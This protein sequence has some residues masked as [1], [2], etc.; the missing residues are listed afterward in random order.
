MLLETLSG[1]FRANKFQR[2]FAA[3]EVLKKLKKPVWNVVY[4]HRKGMKSSE[5]RV[6]LELNMLAYNTTTSITTDITI[7]RFK[8]MYAKYSTSFCVCLK[9]VSP[10]IYQFYSSKFISDN[11]LNSFNLKTSFFLTGKSFWINHKRKG[12]ICQHAHD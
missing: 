6:I 5:P 4:R 2:W 12:F 1:S 7:L 8:N 10:S 9:H 3:P 11:F